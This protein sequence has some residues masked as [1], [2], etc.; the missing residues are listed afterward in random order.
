MN[1]FTA[2]QIVEHRKA[3]AKFKTQAEVDAAIDRF[4]R[5]EAAAEARRDRCEWESPEYWKHHDVAVKWREKARRLM[6]L[7]S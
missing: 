7:G 5:L 3:F 1:R 4:I 6:P 2:E